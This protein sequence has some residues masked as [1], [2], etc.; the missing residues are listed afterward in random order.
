[1]GFVTFGHKTA[2]SANNFYKLN[3]RCVRPQTHKS[4]GRR[5]NH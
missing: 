2:R 3:A 1:M 4:K 5:K